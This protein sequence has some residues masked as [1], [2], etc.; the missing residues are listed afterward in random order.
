LQQGQDA[1]LPDQEER[2]KSW[3]IEQFAFSI[4]Q[5]HDQ[6]EWYS[7][8]R[9]TFFADRY[10]GHGIGPNGGSGRC[11][12]AGTFQVKGIG[13]TPLVGV[14]LDYSHSHGSMTL[15]EAL[16]EAVFAEV[17]AQEMPLGAIPV[18]AVIATGTKLP[19]GERKALLVRPN[20]FRASYLQRAVYHRPN[21]GVAS[22]YRADVARVKVM[23]DAALEP[24]PGSFNLGLRADPIGDFARN[25]AVQ[26][27]FAHVQRLYFGVCSTSNLSLK[28]EV[29]DFGSARSQLNWTSAVSMELAPAFGAEDLE[30]FRESLRDVLFYLRRY[31]PHSRQLES[32]GA[33]SVETFDVTYHSCLR[34]ELLRMANLANTEIL[35]AVGEELHRIL[36]AYFHHQQRVRTSH[37][38]NSVRNNGPWLYEAFLDS[39]ST[40]NRERNLYL[41]V[42]AALSRNLPPRRV[43]SSLACL[44]RHL[45]P[46]DRLF[47]E[48]MQKRLYREVVEAV[49]DNAP[50]HELAI[51]AK[52]FVRET[53]SASRRVFPGIASGDTVVGTACDPWSTAVLC[54]DSDTGAKTLILSGTRSR[55]DLCIFNST[56]A[57]DDHP[58]DGRP[59]D[60]VLRL[61]VPDSYNGEASSF[62]VGGTPIDVPDIDFWY[63]APSERQEHAILR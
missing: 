33:Q 12:V 39:A 35:G 53:V 32:C 59:D 29:V 49:E 40:S 58:I 45:R 50:T 3:V 24:A 63:E 10:G 22:D 57:I 46:R 5:A 60:V 41:A 47:R 38:D 11:A 52:S 51:R 1:R 6:P 43:P 42:C 28:G 16:R 54:R 13:R 30:L 18:I 9:K 8:V 2:I 27:A 44:R 56:I 26:M 34:G 17:A 15:E 61:R 21:V 48:A 19:W 36:G 62:H 55:G 20:F 37:L 14:G 23:V 4:P 25:V 31:G 7:G